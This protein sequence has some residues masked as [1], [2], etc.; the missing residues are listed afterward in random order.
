[1]VYILHFEESLLV[2]VVAVLLGVL[3]VAKVEGEVD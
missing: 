2:V 3:L 1:V